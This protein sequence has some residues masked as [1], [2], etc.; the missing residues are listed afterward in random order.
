LASLTFSSPDTGV[1]VLENGQISA[2]TSPVDYGIFWDYSPS[3]G[4][5]AY[6]SEFYHGS[7]DSRASISDLWVYDYE[8]DTSEQ[9]L[10]DN[11]NWASWAP[12][13]ARLTAVV[14]NTEEEA[15]DLVF[16]S[17][18]NQVE[19]IAKCAFN[20]FSWSPNGDALA[21][22]HKVDW[23]WTQ[24][25]CTGTFLVSFPNGTQAPEREVQRV[26]DFGSEE[27][28]SG[29]ILDK[30][31]WVMEQNA[32][33]FPDAPFWV[34][35]MDGSPPFV[36]QTPGGED[37]L[38]L[39]RPHNN[40]WVPARRLL[41][42]NTEGGRIGPGG[43]WVYEL[44]EDLR[45]IVDYYRVG[46]LGGANTEI[47]LVSWWS[48]GESILVLDSD[49]AKSDDFLNEFWG[50]PAVWSLIERKWIEWE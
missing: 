42:G 12:D 26:S 15:M 31:I 9:W 17:G 10:A 49:S 29:H 1:L 32:L 23:S 16:V 5:L 22:V 25:A 36:P 34:V 39:P 18:P 28:V 21:Y 41:I 8:T 44:S 7:T 4:L 3:H 50:A 2:E 13:G 20:F 30:P 45:T 46:T 35:P 43:V 24:E 19:L 37:P 11:V 38:D 14:Y 47:T 6:S 33:I 27:L 40:L 48:V